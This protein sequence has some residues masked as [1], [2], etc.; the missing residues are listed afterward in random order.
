[1]LSVVPLKT[2]N[3]T[4]TMIGFMTVGTIFHADSCPVALQCRHSHA[5]RIF[6]TRTDIIIYSRRCFWPM[7]S[8]FS[9]NLYM[10]AH[11]AQLRT[12]LLCSV[13]VLRWQIHTTV[14]RFHLTN[15][16][17]GATSVALSKHRHWLHALAAFER[18]S[19]I[20]EI[21]QCF[22][23]QDPGGWHKWD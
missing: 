11:T 17:N 3:A 13:P 7:F 8:P 1:M 4:V 9:V 5:S 12:F 10:T 21:G 18:L 2:N 6:K 14:R 23:Q 20:R 15:W 22:L 19:L 16:N